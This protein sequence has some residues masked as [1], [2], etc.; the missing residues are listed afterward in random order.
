MAGALASERADPELAFPTLAAPVGNPILNDGRPV[1]GMYLIPATICQQNL[2]RAPAVRA[3]QGTKRRMAQPAGGIQS[4]G[5]F[6]RHGRSL[7]PW[8]A[9][10]A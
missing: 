3:R 10:G 8:A 4:H 5:G 1:S 9:P 2:V 6:R 7:R